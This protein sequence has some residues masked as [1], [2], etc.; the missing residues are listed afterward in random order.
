MK[1]FLLLLKILHETWMSPS[2]TTWAT[3]VILASACGLAHLIPLI[4]HLRTNLAFLLTGKRNNRKLFQIKTEISEQKNLRKVANI[5]L[6]SQHPLPRSS[7]PT[8]GPQD[9]C[10]SGRIP[11]DTVTQ[12]SLLWNSDPAHLPSSRLFLSC[13]WETDNALFFFTLGPRLSRREPPSHLPP[14]TS[15]RGEPRLAG[16]LTIQRVQ[17]LIQ[18]GK[19]RG[20]LLAK[21]VSLDLA[22]ASPGNTGRALRGKRGTTSQPLC[23]IGHQPRWLP[24]SRQPSCHL[25][26]GDPTER[27]RSQLCRG[28]VF[29]QGE[30]L[31]ATAWLSEKCS[32]VALQAVKVP[33]LPSRLALHS[34]AEGLPQPSETQPLTHQVARPQLCTANLPYSVPQAQTQAP[35][36]RSPPDPPPSCPSQVKAC[37]TTGP[38]RQQE[39]QSPVPVENQQLAWPLQTPPKPSG[40]KLPRAQE[41]S[42]QPTLNLPQGSQ[43]SQTPKSA[44][45]LLGESNSPEL[46]EPTELARVEGFWRDEHL[47]RPAFGIQTSQPGMQLLGKLPGKGQGQ[48][49]GKQGPPIPSA[50]AHQSSQGV[51]NIGS[52]SHGRALRKGPRAFQRGQPGDA[53]QQALERDPQS[54]G[55][56]SQKVRGHYDQHAERDPIKPDTCDTG[57]RSSMGPG[58]K[59]LEKSLREHLGRK[60]GQIREGM[61]PLC[62]RKSWLAASHNVNHSNTHATPR[63]PV[64]SKGRWEA[65]I[66]TSQELPFLDHKTHLMLEAHIK[67]SYLKHKWGPHS[68]PFSP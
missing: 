4:P 25:A 55:R 60:L 42:A 27:E 40:P 13:C 66:S 8:P 64:R 63:E 41:H 36:P 30:N 3:D 29:L 18:E 6:L 10:S 5:I 14:H 26:L 17:T 1:R 9:R 54:S 46:Q 38:T 62:V 15:F 51:Q 31:L 19:G 22:L 58:R 24:A 47:P 21:A 68:R 20:G 56:T 12:G 48:A 37:T 23:N 35:D 7:V 50:P 16:T 34:R 28:L 57:H 49:Q 59:H 33:Q 11:Q 65:R 39:A 53:L 32:S 52:C 2:S 45:L 61:I 43:A 67:R 44:H